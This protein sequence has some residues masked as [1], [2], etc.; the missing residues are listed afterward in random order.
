LALLPVVAMEKLLDGV[1]FND[2][3][4]FLSLKGGEFLQ[5]VEGESWLMKQPRIRDKQ[6]SIDLAHPRIS[7]NNHILIKL[8][9]SLWLPSDETEID[10]KNV[11][12]G[13]IDQSKRV[14]SSPLNS[15]YL[16]GRQDEVVPRDPLR[17][18]FCFEL[19]HHDN[20]RVI[21]R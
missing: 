14:H 8:K 9:S 4:K 7:P 13:V 1:S 16:I 12:L 17:P 18:L 11:P 6:D 19:H 3:L 20:M 15:R 5:E 2:A 10:L 21:G